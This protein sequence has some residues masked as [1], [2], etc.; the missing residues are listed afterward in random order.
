MNAAVALNLLKDQV[1]SDEVQIKVGRLLRFTKE[2]WIHALDI[3]RVWEINVHKEDE[4]LIT[5]KF[6]DLKEKISQTGLDG[7]FE[8]TAWSM[9]PMFSVC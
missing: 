3:A 5:Q 9:T 6:G 4:E 8:K 2:K 7:K 1:W